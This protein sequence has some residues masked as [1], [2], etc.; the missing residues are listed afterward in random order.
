MQK[1][2]YQVLKGRGISFIDSKKVKVKGSEVGFS[3]ANINKILQ[4]KQELTIMQTQNF[5]PISKSVLLQ[6]HDTNWKN[7]LP[8][9]QMEKELSGLLNQLFKPEQEEQMINQELL[10]KVKKKKHRFK[11]RH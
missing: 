1:P 9:T 4:L 3:L 11:I 10:H 7:N 8:V 5:S 2:G 6:K